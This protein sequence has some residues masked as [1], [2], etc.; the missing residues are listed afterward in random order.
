M[1]MRNGFLWLRNFT[2]L[3]LMVAVV[4]ATSLTAMAAPDKKA[5]MGELLVSGNGAD[6]AVLLNGEKALSGRTFFSAGTIATDASSTASVKLGELGSV[7]I[8]P[9]ST[10]SLSFG[11]GAINGTLSSGEVT[12]MN[13]EGIA[14]NIVNAEGA[15]L[16]SS[17]NGVYNTNALPKKDDDTVSKGGQTALV[18]IFAGVV[19]G[20]VIYLLTRDNDDQVGTTVSPVR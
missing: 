12:V 20:T 2:A 1:R 7:S 15:S 14:V 9:N 6:A 18:L 19:A 17:N 3:S 13:S 11:N 5:A 16:N 10:F 4:A 8:A